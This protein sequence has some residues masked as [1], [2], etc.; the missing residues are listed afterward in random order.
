[1]RVGRNVSSGKTLSVFQ[2]M[3]EGVS[4]LGAVGIGGK[5]ADNIGEKLGRGARV[6]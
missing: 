1:M 2:E 5:R 3:R 6:S 4:A